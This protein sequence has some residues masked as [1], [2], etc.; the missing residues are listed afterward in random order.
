MT[1]SEKNGRKQGG[2]EGESC[3]DA[4]P[5]LEK[6]FRLLFWV[7]VPM[8]ITTIADVLFF[9]VLIPV[10]YRLALLTGAVCAMVYGLILMQ[11]KAADIRYRR[12]GICML[13]FAAGNG[14]AASFPVSSDTFIWTFGIA[15]AACVSA[16]MG[17]YCEFH[18]HGEV[19]REA[20]RIL[21]EKWKKL[22]PWCV[23]MYAG[24]E[25]CIVICR[26]NAVLGLLVGLIASV[27]SIVVSITRLMYLGRGAKGLRKLPNPAEKEKENV[28]RNQGNEMRL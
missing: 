12:A 5:L 4:G 9:L 16:L 15:S 24:M 18:A 2:R 11:L 1:N 14:L 10:L 6:G 7:K 23:G 26:V 20:D 22:W 19:L 25:G 3:H 8:T 21:A 27:G 28:E 17:M 13:I